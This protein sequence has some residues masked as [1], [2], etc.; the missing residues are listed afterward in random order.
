MET[1]IV[2][3]SLRRAVQAAEAYGW[4]MDSLTLWVHGPPSDDVGFREVDGVVVEIRTWPIYKRTALL[5][6]PFGMDGWSDI[7]VETR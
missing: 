4:D 6:E 1:H 7:P 2:L 3:S 5:G